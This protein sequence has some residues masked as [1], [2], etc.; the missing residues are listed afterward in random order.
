[1]HRLQPALLLT[2]L[3]ERLPPA[4]A[5]PSLSVAQKCY[6]L[7]NKG[8]P[9]LIKS[10]FCQDHLQVWRPRELLHALGRACGSRRAA[11]LRLLLPRWERGRGGIRGGWRLRPQAQAARQERALWHPI[12]PGH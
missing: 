7:A 10:A 5:P 2:R 12:G 11:R 9:L 8:Q 1:M 6:D 4:L 3:T